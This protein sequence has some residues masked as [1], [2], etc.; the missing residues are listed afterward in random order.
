MVLMFVMQLTAWGIIKEKVF[1]AFS[2]VHLVYIAYIVFLVAHGCN[3]WLN[4][5]FP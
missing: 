1:E 2:Y 4:F 5:G 3:F